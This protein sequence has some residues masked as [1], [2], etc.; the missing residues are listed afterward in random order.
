R[1][2][3][4]VG[5]VGAHAVDADAPGRTAER[6][7]VGARTDGRERG[8]LALVGAV[9]D[10]RPLAAGLAAPLVER[11]GLRRARVGDVAADAVDADAPGRPAERAAVGVGADGRRG[12]A[13]AR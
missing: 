12:R 9:V 5:D 4:G 8:A 7:A 10:E 1:R 3:A 6:A 11:A 13:F 2:S